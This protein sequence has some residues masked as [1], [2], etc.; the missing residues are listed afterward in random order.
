MNR[1]TITEHD[2]S[3]NT[4][5]IREMTVEEYEVAIA[6]GWQPDETAEP[7]EP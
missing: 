5:V 3:S 2:A 6:D 7:S 4:T 1:P